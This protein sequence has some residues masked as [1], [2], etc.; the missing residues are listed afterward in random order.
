M[1]IA[2]VLSKFIVYVPFCDSKIPAEIS[3]EEVL[4]AAHSFVTLGLKEAGYEY[5]NID[6]CLSPAAIFPFCI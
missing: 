6:V 5:V 4:S 3:E 2:V 1:H